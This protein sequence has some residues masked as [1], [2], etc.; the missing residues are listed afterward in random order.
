VTGSAHARSLS[1][2]R[3]VGPA[4]PA[5]AVTAAGFAAN[6]LSYLVLLIAVRLLASSS[7]SELVVLL[8]VLLVGTVPSFAVQTVTARRVATGETAG[9]KQ[10][11]LIVSLAATGVLA[12]LTPALTAFLHMS[13]GGNLLLVAAC[14][15]AVT[16]LGMFQGV[17]QGQ[18]R[19]ADLS[20]LLTAAAVGRSGCGL[21][22]L[23]VAR[24]STGAVLGTL[25]G[26]TACACVVGARL[27]RAVEPGLAGGPLREV[28][29]ALHAHGTFWFLSTLDVLLAR[30]VL[31]S[32]FAAVYATGS[33]VTRAAIWL[34]QSVAT[35]VFPRLTDAE[36]HKSMLR[37]AIAIVAGA[38][39]VVVAGTAMLPELV[40]RVVGGGKYPELVPSCWMFAALGASLAVLQ[41]GMV[42]GLALRRVRQTVLLWAAVVAD[43]VFVL[44]AGDGATVGS[45]V[46]T[47]ATV[48]A[49]AAAGSVLIG[50]GGLRPRPAQLTDASGQAGGT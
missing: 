4:G 33:V 28:G 23:L 1:G 15:P 43:T 50:T 49:V 45:V 3:P 29:H 2:D 21:L 10:A 34:P 9:M 25:I 46:A 32:H 7:Y 40:A 19:F 47:V 5:A 37:R 44:A 13:G 24:N 38:G 27:H 18:R 8:N 42:A 22:G 41:L 12:V 39:V 30:H 11:T 6:L 16:A 26:V 36:R 31:P 48:T 14:L 35:L 20:I 17:L